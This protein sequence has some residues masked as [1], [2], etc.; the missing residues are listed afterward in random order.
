LILDTAA[1]GSSIDPLVYD[2][3]IKKHYDKIEDFSYVT[4][5]TVKRNNLGTSKVMTSDRARIQ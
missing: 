2:A 5:D 3:I 4:S 1:Q